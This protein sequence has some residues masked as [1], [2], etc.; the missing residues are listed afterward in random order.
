MIRFGAAPTYNHPTARAAHLGVPP[1]IPRARLA[2][3]AAIL[4]ACFASRSDSVAQDKEKE[5]DTKGKEKA[6]AVENMKKIRV[7]NP[8]IEESDNFL[9]VGSIPKEKAQALSKVLEKT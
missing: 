8:T 1:M 6:A 7:D 5:K 9:V 3:L 2:V 4:A